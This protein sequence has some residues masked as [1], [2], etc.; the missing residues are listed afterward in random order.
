ME[1]EEYAIMYE[2]EEEHWWFK[3]KRKI[4]FSQIEQHLRGKNNLKILD[5]GCGTG[6]M[7]KNFQRYG[8]VNGVDIETTALNFC[9]NRGLTKLAQA[10]IGS[11][12]FK[13]NNFNIVSVFDVLYHKGVK[14]DIGALKEIF[15]IL[16]PHGILILTDS[17][18]MK[19]WSKH[20]IATH[21]RE[22]YTIP[23]LASRL[24]SAGFKIKKITYFNTVLYPLVFIMRKI[25]NLLNK[26]KIAVS[27]IRTANPLLNFALYSIFAVE[28]K[29]LKFCDLP[30]GV[31]I[32]AIA[33]K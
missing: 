28:S 33:E 12:P 16:K 14:D 9:H 29:L 27:N 20:D 2:A 7:M 17:A 23:K 15:R 19:L 21:A 18:D 32:L 4:I 3:G 8:K 13:A 24:K 1:K 31:S 11:L 25:D 22:R 30:F 6:I 26:D 5:I 10:D